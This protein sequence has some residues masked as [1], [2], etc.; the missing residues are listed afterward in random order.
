MSY[1]GGVRRAANTAD[2]LT[3]IEAVALA[4][5]GAADEQDP[6][7]LVIR[8]PSLPDG[9]QGVLAFELGI[10]LPADIDIDLVVAENGHLTVANRS[11]SSSA[12]TGRGDLR[13]IGCH[14]AIKAKTGR[15]Q[16]IVD[17]HRGD[18]DITAAIG[19]M[20][21][22]VREPGQRIRLDTGD[23]TVQC[24]IPPNAGFVVDARA[25]VGRCGSS[26]GLDVESPTEF[27]AA[28]TGARGDAGTKIVLR[29]GTGHIQLGSK[30]FD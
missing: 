5:T 15:G 30:V 9:V 13:F 11:A 1:A 22:F 17:D 27:S 19:S 3:K 24:Y 4:F 16:I 6:S 25:A 12:V 8:A 23:G 7:T 10:R 18:L 20:Q 2:D 21:V 28:M 29:T 26:F 14:G